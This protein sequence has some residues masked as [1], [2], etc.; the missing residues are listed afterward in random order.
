MAVQGIMT[1]VFLALG[2]VFALGRGAWMIAGYN[3][4]SDEEKAKFDEKKLLKNMSRMM[5]CCA[6]CT[7]LGLV[8]TLTG[9]HWLVTLSFCLIAVVIIFFIIRV[10]TK[11]K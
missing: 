7:A 2:V 8:G 3:T 4:M 10:N 6:A 1:L 11:T 9:T 5:F